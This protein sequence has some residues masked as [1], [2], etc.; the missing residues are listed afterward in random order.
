MFSLCQICEEWNCVTCWWHLTKVVQIVYCPTILMIFFSLSSNSILAS[1]N[2][3]E[4]HSKVTISDE[5]SHNKLGHLHVEVVHNVLI[6]NNK[7]SKFGSLF[8]VC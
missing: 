5:L 2:N 6:R 7:S 3:I 4:C 1:A 8:Y